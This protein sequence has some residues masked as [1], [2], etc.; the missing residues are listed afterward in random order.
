MK[1]IAPLG[2]PTSVVFGFLRH[3]RTNARQRFD[4]D[5]G[6]KAKVYRKIMEQ[7]MKLRVDGHPNGDIIDRIGNRGK[8]LLALDD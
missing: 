5:Y 7:A 6:T 4:D 3:C 8:H 1:L 2:S